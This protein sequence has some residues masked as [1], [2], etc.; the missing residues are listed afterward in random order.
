VI[1]T[2][3]RTQADLTL[4]ERI[5][6]RD[7]S[8]VG[9]LYDRH[10]QLLYSLIDRIVRDDGEAEDILQ[11][12]VLRVWE[13][14]ETYDPALGTPTAWLVRIA[15]NRAI[16][17]VRARQSRPVTH[18][19]EEV[20]P[21]VT[22]D[23]DLAPGPERSAAHAEQQQAIEAALRQI[24]DEQRVLIEQAFFEGYTQSELAARFKLPLGT[25]KTRIRSGMLSMRKHLQHLSDRE[26]RPREAYGH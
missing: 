7:G 16:D 6:R 15:R 22:V 14:A 17:R 25:V 20:L 26:P 18:P 1:G 11:E 21:L 23:E 10:S 3:D 4:L 2:S 8:A 24:P 5:A 12:V 9:E 13:K 19:S